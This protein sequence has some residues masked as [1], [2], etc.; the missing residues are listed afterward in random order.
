MAPRIPKWATRAVA[1]VVGVVVSVLVFDGLTTLIAIYKPERLH[2][3]ARKLAKQSNRV[4]LWA[5][6]RFG[7][8]RNS[9][10]VVVYHKGRKSGR[11]YAT[12]LCVSR[13]GDDFIVGA[14]WGPNAD[15]FL[16]L[17]TTPR[18]RLRYQGDYH[19]VEGEVIDIDTAHVLLGGP[20]TCGCWE[21]GR[22]QQCVLFRPIT[23][24]VEDPHEANSPAL[25]TSRNG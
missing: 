1:V 14:Y 19:N 13:C 9:E 22:T 17:Q 8:D 7:L 12:P 21:Q 3:A 4:W 11:E 24:D 18:A 20:S 25:A 23:E 10:S 6:E 16:N 15:W 5:I 2:R